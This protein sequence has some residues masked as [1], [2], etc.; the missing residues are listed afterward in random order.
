MPLKSVLML[1]GVERLSR[2]GFYVDK[3]TAEKLLMSME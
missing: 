1:L 2:K 3:K